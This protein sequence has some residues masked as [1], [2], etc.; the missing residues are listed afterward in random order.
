ME[1]H[2][3]IAVTD[4]NHVRLTVSDIDR[5]RSFYDSV[6]GFDVAY[7]WDPDADE[8]TK[9]ALW[10][11]FGGVIYKFGGGLL[12]LRP[13]APS[14]DTFAEDRCG[15][16]HLSFTVDTRAALEDAVKTLDELGIAHEGIKDAG[17]GMSIVEF[18]DPDN[19]ALELTGPDK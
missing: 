2:V 6:F 15:L 12:G 10:F 8:E 7:A 1:H 11:L 5:S 3:P 19:I 14:D 13:V 17:P 16:D 18:R 4:Y 9:K